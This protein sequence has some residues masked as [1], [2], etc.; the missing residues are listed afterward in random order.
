MYRIL[1]DPRIEAAKRMM[2]RVKRILCFVS[3]KGGVGKSVLSSASALLF[4]SSGRKTGLLDLDFHG[5]SAHTILGARVG[6][7][8]NRGIIPHEFNGIK[9]MSIV[10]FAGRK[11][12][13]WRG[14]DISQSILELLAIT[15]W[16]ELDFLVIDMPPGTGEEILETSKILE[17]GEFVIVTTPSLLSIETVKRLILALKELEVEIS[18][19]IENMGDGNK[20]KKLSREYKIRFL[21]N[22]RYDE[23]LEKAI[24][25]PNKLLK[26]KISKDLQKILQIL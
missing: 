1:R 8:E 11:P 23:N 20:A 2:S 21:G 22:V 12:I 5:P 3:G 18:G 9:I 14:S 13:L 19:V 17:R 26:T 15:R 25:K 7:G 10:P 6:F 16:G 4:S 24:G